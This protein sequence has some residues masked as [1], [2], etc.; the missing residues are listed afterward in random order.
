MSRLAK[1]CLVMLVL[2]ASTIL[3]YA[4][5]SD[6]IFFTTLKLTPD[7]V[8]YDV[9]DGYELYFYKDG[10]TVEV[11][12]IF[13]DIKQSSEN[14]AD[15]IFNILPKEKFKVDSLRLEFKML[16]PASALMLDN[17]ESSQSLPFIYTRTDYD[18][19]VALDFP[20][21]ASKT[22]ET[23]TINCWL[24]LLEI[25]PITKDNLILDISFSVHEES[26]LKIVKYGAHSAIE[27]DI[28]FTAK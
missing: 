4:A 3:L 1:L 10:M 26:V 6:N 27:L 23:I 17:P 7:N 16:Q 20:D 9:E 25:D 28:P 21:L 12:T 11:A 15:I 24:N 13:H 14:L 5:A 19:S 22:S 2:I 18:S 8:V